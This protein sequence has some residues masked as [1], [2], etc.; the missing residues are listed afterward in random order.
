MKRIIIIISVL[1]ILVFGITV[2]Y[3][4]NLSASENASEK[5][6]QVIPDNASLVFEYKNETS[7]YDIF[8]DFTLFSDILGKESTGHLHALK[9]VFID[10]DAV[11]YALK[12]NELFFSLHATSPNEADFLVITPINEKQIKN[13]LQLIELI[14][15]K[16]VIE[17]EGNLYYLSF[18]NNAKFY[19]TFTNNLALGSFNEKLL[20]E[21]SEQKTEK[22]SNFSLLKDNVSSQ[23]NKNS[24]ANLYINFSNF[25]KLLNNFSDKKNPIETAS[26]KNFSAISSL[27]I[28]YQNNAF[29]FSGTT[30]LKNN[31]KEYAALFLNQSPGKNTLAEILPYDAASYIFYYVS[32]FEKFKSELNQLI[33]AR[34]ETDKK[35]TQIQTVSQKNSINLD[36]ELYPAI[37]NEFGLIQL[38]SRDKIGIIKSNKTNRLSFILS[39]ISSST[40]E[41]NIRKFN[42]SDLLYYYLGDP[43][44][45]FRRPF[46][47]VIENHVIIANNIITLKRFLQNYESQN[48]LSRTD[49]NIYFQQYLSNQ[50][51]I[52]YFIHNGNS[53]GNIRAFLSRSSY[54]KMNGENFDWKNIYGLSIQFSADKNKFFTNL[55]M[56]KMPKAVENNVESPALDS[57]L[58]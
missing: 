30:E 18:N 39:T 28:N 19:F 12:Q 10:N 38:A 35:N 4:K 2:F 45:E 25:G 53:K 21:V 13:S 47:T 15:S 32:D 16:Y 9:S 44:K 49:K 56:S 57:L 20:K 50:G 24:I 6:F 52:F 31:R 14:K 22:T 51:N 55:Y 37:G 58:N 36:R 5:V 26:L 54:R 42:D 43:F 41:T 3:F 29:M 1:V 40:G 8:K 7:F 34:K 23:R 48:F 46:Y 17:Q 27:N 33:S 11:A